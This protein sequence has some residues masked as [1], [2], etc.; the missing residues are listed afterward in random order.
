MKLNDSK[1][2][3]LVCGRKEEVIIA[4]VGNANIIESH[5]VKLLGM[6]IDR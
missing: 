5:E 3:F 2:H 1:C 6:T 4:N